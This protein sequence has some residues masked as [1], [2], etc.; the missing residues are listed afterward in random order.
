MAA[1]K[2]PF[3]DRL[4]YLDGIQYEASKSPG[5]G[6]YNPRVTFHL[7][8]KRAKTEGTPIKTKP[9]DWRKK[10]EIIDKKQPLKA[11]D[12]RTYNPVPATYALFDAAAK[13]K[14]NKNLLGKVDRFKTFSSGSGLPPAKYN[15]IQEWRG[16][17]NAKPKKERHGL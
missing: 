8:Q 11:P 16:K 17:D 1:R 9:E 14:Q 7:I 2:I 4:T 15:I 3:Q 10:H 12:M 6:N 13:V 5:V